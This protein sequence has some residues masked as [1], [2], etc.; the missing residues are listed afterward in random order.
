M[1]QSVGYL[2]EILAGH[3]ENE[4]MGKRIFDRIS[5][6]DYSSELEFVRDLSTGEAEYLDQILKEAIDYSKQ[7]QDEE[8]VR[9]LT[10]VYEL[11]F[12]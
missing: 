9:Q 3:T 1:D 2:R 10:E 6:R 5:N 11:L 12:V 8:R 7:E 4:S